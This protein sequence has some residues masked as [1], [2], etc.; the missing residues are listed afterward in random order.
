MKMKGKMFCVFDSKAAVYHPPFTMQSTAHGIRAFTETCLD[1]RTELAKY[2][3]DFTLFEIAEFDDSSGEIKMH[4]AKISL[5][6][7]LERVSQH[8]NEIQTRHGG[9][10]NEIGDAP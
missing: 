9:P 4:P 8:K 3:A 6:T 1:Q 2:P 7:A 5:G 10:V